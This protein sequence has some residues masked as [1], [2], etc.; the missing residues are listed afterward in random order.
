MNKN[1]HGR[2]AQAARLRCT[3]RRRTAFGRAVVLA[4]EAGPYGQDCRIVY[5][6]PA[7][8]VMDCRSTAPL[9]NMLTG[10]AA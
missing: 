7:R 1:R 5:Q 8:G 6:H 4:H 2:R 3:I 9:L 10:A